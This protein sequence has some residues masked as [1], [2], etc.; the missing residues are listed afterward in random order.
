MTTRKRELDKEVDY[1][2][3]CK[4]GCLIKAD[5]RAVGTGQGGCLPVSWRPGCLDDG[6]VTGVVL[7][8]GWR[9]VLHGTR[10]A[11]SLCLQEL[12]RE[13]RKGGKRGRARALS[14]NMEV[15]ERL[16]KVIELCRYGE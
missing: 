8:E 11:G 4:R 14:R 6:H 2:L 10:V 16:K 12:N 9:R 3:I 7:L 1:K 5:R 13:V 15:R